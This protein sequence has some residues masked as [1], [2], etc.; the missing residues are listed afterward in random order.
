MTRIVAHVTLDPALPQAAGREA[1]ARI[2]NLN[3]VRKMLASSGRDGT[4][5]D[6]RLSRPK[7]ELCA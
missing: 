5:R 4:E 6:P 7:A 3:D 2:E 1:F